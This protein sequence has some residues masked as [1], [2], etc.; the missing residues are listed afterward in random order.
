MPGRLPIG[1]DRE[2]TPGPRVDVVGGRGGGMLGLGAPVR[3]VDAVPVHF[4]PAIVRR[5][6]VQSEIERDLERSAT[7]LA[8]RELIGD[9]EPARIAEAVALLERRRA[10]LRQREAHARAGVAQL[11][12]LFGPV[13]PAIA[14]EPAIE[15]RVTRME[16]VVIQQTLLPWLLPPHRRVNALPVSTAH[17]GLAQGVVVGLRAPGQ[18]V[19][20]IPESDA[21]V[22]CPEPRSAGRDPR[23][24][25]A[26]LEQR[27]LVAVEVEIAQ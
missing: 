9:V 18:R 4:H 16:I 12:T 21:V 3:W 7:P 1:G 23:R 24:E 8:R 19:A 22:E 15:E 25:C 27:V 5:E 11:E 6:D 10:R 20:I 13:V 26:T 17:A 2:P 14:V